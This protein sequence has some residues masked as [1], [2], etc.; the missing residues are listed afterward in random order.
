MRLHFSL[1]A[2]RITPPPFCPG[3]LP[4]LFVLLEESPAAYQAHH[5]I[6]RKKRG[7]SHGL[8]LK[9]SGPELIQPMT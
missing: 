3:S 5:A 2:A 7:W 6:A 8:P 9:L 4:G 1:A